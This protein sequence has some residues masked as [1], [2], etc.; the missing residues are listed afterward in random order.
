MSD[1]L[2]DVREQLATRNN[3]ATDTSPLVKIKRALQELKVMRVPVLD[4]VCCV[5]CS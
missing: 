4:A 3:S 2:E 5:L 1:R